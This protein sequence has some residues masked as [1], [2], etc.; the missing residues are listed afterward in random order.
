MSNKMYFCSAK[1]C[2]FWLH[3]TGDVE[4]KQFSNLT[5]S[6]W[7]ELYCCKKLNQLCSL[8]HVHLWRCTRKSE[9]NWV[10]QLWRNW[11]SCVHFF[12][13]ISGDVHE[14]LNITGSK[15]VKLETILQQHL[16]NFSSASL[17]MHSWCEL[18][19]TLI[20]SK[21]LPLGLHHWWCD[22]CYTWNWVTMWVPF[23]LHDCGT[24][25]KLY[26]M[27]TTTTT[28]PSKLPFCIWCCMEIVSVHMLF[29][30]VVCVHLEMWLIFCNFS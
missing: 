18:K 25:T 21:L 8:F 12:M 27:N 9:H 6:A 30:S 10:K 3:I 19:S 22:K 29:L 14:N 26:K 15:R 7:Y 1:N 28:T 2:A 24:D 20:L 17:V 16:G 23:T 11:T 4:R 13:Y 5:Y